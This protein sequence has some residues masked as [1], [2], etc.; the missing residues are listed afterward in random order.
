MNQQQNNL[1]HNKLSYLSVAAICFVLVISVRLYSLLFFHCFFHFTLVLPAQIF[2]CHVQTNVLL[3]FNWNK[4]VELLLLV[5][6]ITC[7]FHRPDL[8]T[9][10]I[11]N[12]G[13]LGTMQL[14][15]KL[16]EERFL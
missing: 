6:G 14:N 13:S 7:C 3:L 8:K 2:F 11:K 16:L 9:K 12:D 5:V 1:F 10:S 4:L 15:Y